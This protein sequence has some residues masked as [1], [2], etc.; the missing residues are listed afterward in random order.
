VDIPPAAGTGTLPETEDWVPPEI[1]KG[2]TGPAAGNRETEGPAEAGDSER[3]RQSDVS[4]QV[5]PGPSDLSEECSETDAGCGRTNPRQKWS[6]L[7]Q[8]QLKFE[9]TTFLQS[10]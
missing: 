3:P 2:L 9:G 7:S 4:S 5:D 6:R 8:G 10:R 1:E